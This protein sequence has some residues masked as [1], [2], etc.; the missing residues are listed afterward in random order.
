MILG[1]KFFMPAK[2]EIKK[3]DSIKSHRIMIR[4]GM[5]EQISNGLYFFTPLGLRILNKVEHIV[6]KWHQRAYF[7]ICLAPNLQPGSAWEESGRIQAYGKEL[8][9]FKDRHDRLLILGPTAEEIFAKV[10]KNYIVSERQLP[11]L[12][13]NIQ[14]KYRDEIR[15][16]FGLVRCREFLM[17]DAYSFHFRQQD[18]VECYNNI[19]D[20]YLEMFKE[21][22]LDPIPIQQKDTG[23]VGGSLSHEI[24]IESDEAEDLISFERNGVEMNSRGIEVAHVYYLGTKYSEPM[25][26]KI[27]D[28][29]LEMGCYGV[30]VSRT[31]ASIIQIYGKEDAKSCSVFLP[32]QVAPFKIHLIAS[33]EF[34]KLAEQIHDIDKENIYYD[35]TDKRIGEKFAIADLIGAP[36]RIVIGAKFKLTNSVEVMEMSNLKDINQYRSLLGRIEMLVQDYIKINI[37]NKELNV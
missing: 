6:H 23:P 37:N 3:D 22:G 32:E 13:Y 2:K 33:V 19:I 4:A 12:V 10:A 29:H 18:S 26:L 1:S 27:G 15:P 21:M 7:N 5:I 9:Q 25:Q 30:G 24:F 14:W 35:D 34:Q 20:I 8:M 31:V 17:C 16:R 11:L 36:L 28:R